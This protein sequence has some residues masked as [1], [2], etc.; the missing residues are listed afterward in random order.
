MIESKLK[1]FGFSK[2]LT[3]VYLALMEL[4]RAKAGEVVK[5]SGL[6][7]SVV[8]L[9]LDELVGRDLVSKIE[10]KGVFLFV[11]NDPAH[12]V[13]EAEQKK[14]LAKEI[15]NELKEKQKQIPREIGVYEGLDGI[16]RATF[17]KLDAPSGK[18]IYVMGA[19]KYNVQPELDKHWKQFHKQRIKKGMYFKGLYDRTVDQK[20]VD[21][22]NSSPLS[23]ARYLPEG[24]EMPMWFNVCEDELSIMLPED[25]PPLVFNISSR[26]AAESIIKYF[27]YLWEKSSTKK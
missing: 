15:A 26:A 25:E 7:R 16:V 12:L 21:F 3:T 19:S 1:K 17:K 9:S 6:P 27:N 2:N 10:Y 5:E 23:G 22:R 8:Y 24:M 11:A 20:F 18:T 4:G 14:K 13:D